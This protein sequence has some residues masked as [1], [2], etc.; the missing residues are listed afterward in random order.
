MI[1]T[2][3]YKDIYYNYVRPNLVYESVYDI[4]FELLYDDG[5]R[6]LF[7]DIDNTIISYREDG[8]SFNV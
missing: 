8:V 2:Q 7:F 5:I 1:N 3:F 6:H 4:D